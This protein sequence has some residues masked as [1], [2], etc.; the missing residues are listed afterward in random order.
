MREKYT[1][2][3]IFLALAIILMLLPIFAA[4]NSFLTKTLDAA[5]WYRPIQK[6]VVPW[7]AKLVSAAVYPLGIKTRVTAGPTRFAFYM[8]KDNSIMPV[9]LS[10]NC[11]GW[12]S[13]L[14]LI[15]SLIAGLR[16]RFTNIS[17][18][19]CIVLG[20]FGTLLINVFRMSFIAAGIYYINEIFA[21]VIHDYLAAFLALIWL[22]V[23]WWFSY[24]FVLEERS[25]D[26][27]VRN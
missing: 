5:G 9:D 21:M 22:M 12:Q 7:E 24:S 10:W 16:G 1:F 15:I 14:L 13:M 25:V 27:G 11:L 17:R 26:E 23:F 3:M 8:I 4:L 18:I 2:K 6:H 19:E 20:F